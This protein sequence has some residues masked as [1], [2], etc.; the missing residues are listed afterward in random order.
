[1]IF[2][3]VGQRQLPTGVVLLVVLLTVGGAVTGAVVVATLFAL[4][5][6]AFS[7]LSNPN[8]QNT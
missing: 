8:H 3:S 2:P 7:R 6:A 4:S 5:T 1:M